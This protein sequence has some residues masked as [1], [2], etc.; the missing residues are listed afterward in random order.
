MEGKDHNFLIN[1]SRVCTSANQHWMLIGM[2]LARA[3]LK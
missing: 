2:R 1:Y 3:Q